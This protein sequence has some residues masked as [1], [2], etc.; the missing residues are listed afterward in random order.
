ML[1]DVGRKFMEMRR[2]SPVIDPRTRTRT[3]T[4][5]PQSDVMLRSRTNETWHRSSA[6]ARGLGSRAATGWDSTD[7]NRVNLVPRA[8]PEGLA[9]VD[10]ALLARRHLPRIVPVEK[11]NT[12]SRELLSGLKRSSKKIAKVRNT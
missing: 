6:T 9:Q 8:V 7:L 4:P 10:H 12:M 5:G 11:K 1:A 3:R 2:T